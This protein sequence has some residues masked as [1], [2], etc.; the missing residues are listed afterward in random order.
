MPALPAGMADKYT[1]EAATS[2]NASQF[3]TKAELLEAYHAQRGG[4]LKALDAADSA[5][6]EK[7]SPESV[8]AY[9]P[10]IGAVYS[11]QG[12]HWLMHCGQWV[13]VRRELGKPP[14]F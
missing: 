4:T 2:N 10:T 8:R 3:S 14:L 9:A 13:V 12:S 1:K 7:E 11:L 5:D 6:L